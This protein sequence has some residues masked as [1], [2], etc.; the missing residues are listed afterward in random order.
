MNDDKRPGSSPS[1]K[2]N[3]PA[4]SARGRKK[5]SSGSA[6]KPA[7]R[8][9]LLQGLL[10]LLIAIVGALIGGGVTYWETRSTFAHEDAA[11]AREELRSACVENLKVHMGMVHRLESARTDLTLLKDF[12]KFKKD[13]E[14][15]SK[16]GSEGQASTLYLTA[17]ESIQ[18]EVTR[19]VLATEKAIT[20][21]T[22]LGAST[23]PTLDIPV[24]DEADAAVRTAV[25]DAR[26]SLLRVAQACRSELSS[27]S[28]G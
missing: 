19:F 2:T 21:L 24:D 10:A 28:G 1:G 14:A 18:S 27:T 6:T 5:P 4:A 26:A 20:M 23:S 13:L 3:R 17:P 16:M 25:E 8:S 15:L 7:T 12:G 9:S 22:V 11:R